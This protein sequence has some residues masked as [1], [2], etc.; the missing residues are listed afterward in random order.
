MCVLKMLNISIGANKTSSRNESH[1]Y[2]YFIIKANEANV[3]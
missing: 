1:P 2:K 3:L